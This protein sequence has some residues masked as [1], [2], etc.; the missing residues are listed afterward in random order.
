MPP[1]PYYRSPPARFI[2]DAVGLHTGFEVVVDCRLDTFLASLEHD[3]G[4]LRVPPGLPLEHLVDVTSRSVMQAL[5]PDVLPGFK[6]QYP[7]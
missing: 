5:F 1:D 7:A 4:I 3:T 6:P 2:R